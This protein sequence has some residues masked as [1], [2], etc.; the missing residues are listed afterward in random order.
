MTIPVPKE[1][2]E[3]LVHYLLLSDP[4]F[5]DAYARDLEQAQAILA[6]PQGPQMESPDEFA[7]RMSAETKV[8]AM[9]YRHGHL[10]MEMEPA[11]EV[12][13]SIV[14]FA[15]TVIGDAP[16]YTE[17]KCQWT[18]SPAE[19]VEEYTITVQRIAPGKITPHEAR[20][21]AEHRV[22][23]LEEQIEDMKAHW[24]DA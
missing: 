12:M 13:E 3:R 19:S 23:E 7:A 20:Q 16:N 4:L 22:R 11:K 17:T 8:H 2:L 14:S 15:R 5:G 6:Q 18:V 24:G 21:M 1:L 10:G 9:E